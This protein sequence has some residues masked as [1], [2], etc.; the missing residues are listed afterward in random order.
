[1]DRRILSHD[2]QLRDF[3]AWSETVYKVPKDDPLAKT[4]QE[5]LKKWKDA[6]PQ[7]STGTPGTPIRSACLAGRW[8]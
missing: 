1:M 7:A 4:L 5:T 3:A 2:W 6:K 8:P